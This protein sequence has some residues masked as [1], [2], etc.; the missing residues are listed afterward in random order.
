MRKTV[1]KNVFHGNHG[2]GWAINNR[3]AI[4]SLIDSAN[5]NKGKLVVDTYAKSGKKKGT[6][7]NEK[8]NSKVK[9][10][11]P[12]GV[13]INP[14]DETIIGTYS[15]PAPDRTQLKDFIR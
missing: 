8:N 13:G 9:H 3:I 14:T 1:A 15:E 11:I 10:T 4:Q 7:L 2:I 12:S 5:A 6:K